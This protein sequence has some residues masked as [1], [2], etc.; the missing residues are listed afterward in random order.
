MAAIGPRSGSR[1]GGTTGFVARLDRPAA[2]IPALFSTRPSTGVT[3]QDST[4]TSM[5]MPAFP[6][7]DMPRFEA[8]AAEATSA[9][10]E[11]AEKGLTQAKDAYAK[12]KS[13][14]EEATSVLETTYANASKGAADGL[15]VVEIGRANSNAA[16]DFATELLGAR[17]LAQVVEIS[18]S[19]TRKHIENV[20]EQAKELT[21]LAQK[22]ATTTAEPI[23]DSLS[24]LAKK[25]A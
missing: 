5:K 4:N 10:R 25:A 12:M 1:V 17:T 21:A 14:A 11:M 20:T 19:H 16:F 9:F 18:T 6:T 13:A 3:M 15:K 23:K 2:K 7:L 22:V 8:T 24:G